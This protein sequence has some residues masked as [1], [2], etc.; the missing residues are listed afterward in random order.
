MTLHNFQ[1]KS[2]RSGGKHYLF[3]GLFGEVVPLVPE[4][5]I[6]LIE[7]LSL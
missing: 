7:I 3:K 1:Q 5:V 4:E 6:L 2:H